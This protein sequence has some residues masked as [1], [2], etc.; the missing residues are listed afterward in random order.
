MA[1]FKKISMPP[2]PW[3]G[4]APP[5]RSQGGGH[6]P[7]LGAKSVKYP[8]EGDSTIFYIIIIIII[9]MKTMILMKTMIFLSCGTIN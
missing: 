5:W 9:I 7:L 2:P 6:W 8:S 4:N 3:F 1:H